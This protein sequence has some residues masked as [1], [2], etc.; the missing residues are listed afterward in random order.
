MSNENIIISVYRNVARILSFAGESSIFVGRLA[1]VHK[2]HYTTVITGTLTILINE[3]SAS[4]QNKVT[5]VENENNSVQN[6]AS[7]G[8]TCSAVRMGNNKDGREQTFERKVLRRIFGSVQSTRGDVELRTSREIEVLP[9]MAKQV[10][11]ESEKK[12]EG[13]TRTVAERQD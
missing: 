12:T 2:T 8:E 10:Q 7:A 5:I 1:C 9:Y 13:T 11:L 3:A 4:F 6:N